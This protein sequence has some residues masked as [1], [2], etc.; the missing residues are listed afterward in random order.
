MFNFQYSL[1]NY[2]DEEEETAEEDK[3]PEETDNKENGIIGYKVFSQ[4][5]FFLR[6]G[7]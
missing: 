1:I 6:G 5:F 2:H 4:Y 3:N 7:M